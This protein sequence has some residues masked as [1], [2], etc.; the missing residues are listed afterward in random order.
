MMVALGVLFLLLNVPL[1][2]LI[3]LGETDDE[4]AQIGARQV[5]PWL[6]VL[7]VFPVISYLCGQH[8]NDPNGIVDVSLQAFVAVCWFPVVKVFLVGKRAAAQR[9]IDEPP[10]LIRLFTF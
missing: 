2:Q 9:S 8:F 6:A 7:T 10:P 5:V 3:V 4:E 1:F